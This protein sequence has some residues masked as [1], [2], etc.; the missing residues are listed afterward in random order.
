MKKMKDSVHLPWEVLP[1]LFQPEPA[2]EMVKDEMEKGSPN[3]EGMWRKQ[4][5]AQDLPAEPQRSS[6][7]VSTGF[8]QTS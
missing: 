8:P 4:Q 7:R 5:R 2:R 1:H 3:Q 6:G